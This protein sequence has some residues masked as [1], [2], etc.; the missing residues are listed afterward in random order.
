MAPTAPG[1][2]SLRH[3]GADCIATALLVIAAVVTTS[4]RAVA[5]A[6]PIPSKP[7]VVDSAVWHLR[8][9]LT[10]GPDTL[11]FVYGRIGDHPLMGDWDGNGTATAGVTRRAP[12]G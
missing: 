2:S 5:G 10:A 11:Q 9:T 6:A 4:A 8:N 12:D 1:S 7:G 3:V